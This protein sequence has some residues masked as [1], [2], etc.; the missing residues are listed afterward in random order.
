[1]VKYTKE[2]MMYAKQTSD[3]DQ[4]SENQS[5]FSAKTSIDT[6]ELKQAL[7]ALSPHLHPRIIQSLSFDSA[8][9]KLEIIINEKAPQKL[10]TVIHNEFQNYKFDQK[11][12]T[13]MI[14]VPQKNI[15]LLIKEA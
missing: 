4:T 15:E 14:D 8:Q 9:G 1:M 10:L 11:G 12:H 13:I 6:P 5:S 7:Y 2:K 3:D